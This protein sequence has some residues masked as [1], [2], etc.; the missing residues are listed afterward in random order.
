MSESGVWLVA[1]ALLLGVR[2]SQ[3]S[4]GGAFFCAMALVSA[5]KGDTD[6]HMLFLGLAMVV[7]AFSTLCMVLTLACAGLLVLQNLR[8]A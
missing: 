4:G 6:F 3:G 1:E 7:D 5:G 8:I 2:A